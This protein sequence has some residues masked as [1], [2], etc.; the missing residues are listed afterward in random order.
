MCRS[1]SS[2]FASC[3]EMPDGAVTI[4]TAGRIRASA[5][6]SGECPQV[7]VVHPDQPQEHP[8][9]RAVAGHRGDIRVRRA[10]ERGHLAQRRVRPHVQLTVAEPGLIPLDAA[11][12]LGLLL[13]RLVL[14][15]E[16]DPAR[17][18]QRD[19]HPRRR[20]RLHD[21]AAQRQCHQQRRLLR[22][23]GRRISGAD[24]LTFAGVQSS[25]VRPGI[26]RYSFSDRETSSRI[27]TCPPQ[28]VTVSR[29]PPPCAAL[30]GRAA[31]R[32]DRPRKLQV[33]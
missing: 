2:V 33:W 21:C 19:R 12:I 5:D 9:G 1:H 18:R 16:S 4:S 23:A 32:H 31:R 22:P 25:P 11:D 8:V 29:S 30:A 26:S 24:R 3:K 6:R 14:V 28:K 7:E 10:Q 27:R 13:D 15:N 17:L 20:H